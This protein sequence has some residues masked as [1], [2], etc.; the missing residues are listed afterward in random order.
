MYICTIY[1]YTHKTFIYLFFGYHFPRKQVDL[2]R[3][4]RGNCSTKGKLQGNKRKLQYQ[5]YS[6]KEYN[7]KDLEPHCPKN[8]LL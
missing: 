6:R 3:E 2:L 5:L 4:I 1:I 8:E 7:C